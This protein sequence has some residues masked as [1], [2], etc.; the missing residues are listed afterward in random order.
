MSLHAPIHFLPFFSSK[1]VAPI[2]TAD[3]LVRSA[4]IWASLDGSI[5]SISVETITRAQPPLST[6]CILLETGD[7]LLVLDV[8]R[9]GS[10]PESRRRD[11]AAW[12][13]FGWTALTLPPHAI[14]REARFVNACRIWR[15]RRTPVPNAMRFQILD[16]LRSDGPMRVHELLG[17]LNADRDPLPVLFALSCGDE[18]AIDLDGDLG[19]DSIVRI[20]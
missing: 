10:D 11:E 2:A 7:D 17:E 12:R 20:R 16:R 4:L 8:V 1:C 6:E 3:E 19:R 9:F 5:T 13:A 14:E 18:V 15:D